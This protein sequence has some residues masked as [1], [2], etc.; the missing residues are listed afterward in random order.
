[1]VSKSFYCRFR[2]TSLM[3]SPTTLPLPTVLL[4][5][6]PTLSLTQVKPIPTITLAIFSAWTVPPLY[7]HL[8]DTF[9][10]ISGISGD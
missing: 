3:S 8:T 2:H 7:L 6:S 10:G 5:Q 4:P 9:S 1:M